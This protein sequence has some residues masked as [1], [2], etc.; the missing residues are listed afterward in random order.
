MYKIMLVEDE[1][2]VR[3]NMTQNIDWES[4]GFHM[5]C[6]CENGQEAID[7]LASVLPD[8][9]IT[10]ICMPLV[11]GLEL[12]RYLQ[13][14]YPSVFV[15]ILTGYNEFNY[16]QQAVKLRVHDFVLKPVVPGEFC[17]ML[18]KLAAELDDRSVRRDDMRNLYHRAQQAEAALRGALFKRLVRENLTLADLTAAAQQ[19]GLVFDSEVYCVLLADTAENAARVSVHT[20]QQVADAAQ[21]TATRY[22]HCQCAMF[23]DRYAMMIFGGRTQAEVSERARDAAGMLAPAMQRICRHPVQ[24]GIGSCCSDASGLHR[25]AR[26]AYHALGYG[27]ALERNVVIDQRALAAER[28]V[29]ASDPLPSERAVMKAAEAR[30][31]AAAQ[32]KL[33]AL[34]DDIRLR[35]LHRDACVPVLQH[36]RFA[37]LDMIPADLQSAAPQLAPPEEWHY[38]GEVQQS[39]SQLLAFLEQTSRPEQDDP[40][41][42]CAHEAEK[43]IYA[44]YHDMEFSLAELLASLNVSKSYFSSVFKAQTGQTFVEYLTALRMERAKYLL[45]ATALCTYEI[46]EQTGFSDPHYFSITFKRCV[47]M[48]PRAFREAGA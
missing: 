48:T 3:E 32:E 30:D 36:L 41:Q 15:V 21:V 22:P 28:P 27:L 12:A 17:A 5:A 45:K 24:A 26:E 29:T 25:C 18:Q 19:A 34:F 20:V 9:V 11:D 10:D 8:V 43:Y 31:F 38:A 2:L 46:A 13:A 23:D 14:H 33:A 39:F 42:R 47:G 40:A 4:Y 6:A 37:L 16:A 35:G 7:N 1:T 44:H